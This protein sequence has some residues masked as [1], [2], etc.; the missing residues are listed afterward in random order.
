MTALRL[1]LSEQLGWLQPAV[2]PVAVSGARVH[3]PRHALLG[4]IHG[5]ARLHKSLRGT[6]GV[7]GRRLPVVWVVRSDL[8]VGVRFNAETLG[9]KSF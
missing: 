2:F 9:K 4:A 5:G 1:L 6:R 7:R 3:G 8:P